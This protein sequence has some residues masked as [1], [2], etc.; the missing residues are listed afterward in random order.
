MFQATFKTGMLMM[1]ASHWS[2]LQLIMPSLMLHEGSLSALLW[3]YF[4]VLTLRTGNQI[5][6]C[7]ASMPQRRC[8]WRSWASRQRC[9]SASGSLLLAARCTSATGALL[10][11]ICDH[12]MLVCQML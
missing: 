9:A 11:I 8:R 1:L 5:W 12:V 6:Q 7:C 10:S 4:A 2:S 3:H